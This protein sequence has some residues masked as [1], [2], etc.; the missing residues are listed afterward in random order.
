M[1]RLRPPA[2]AIAMLAALLLLPGCVWRE[3]RD[4][5]RSR[6][7]YEAC[8]D[9]R[10]VSADECVARRA[11]YDASTRRYEEVSRLKWGCDPA[12]E[13]CPTPR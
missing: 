1:A 12:Q 6:E 9:E 11:L 8:I 3:Y 4:M 5:V 2:I 10:S 13:D 7:H